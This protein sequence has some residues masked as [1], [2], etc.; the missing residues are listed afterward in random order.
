MQAATNL[1]IGHRGMKDDAA[2]ILE[3]GESDD[4]NLRTRHKV[5]KRQGL[6][7]HQARVEVS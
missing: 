1:G 2:R 3:D 6:A 5:W 4:T 7:R